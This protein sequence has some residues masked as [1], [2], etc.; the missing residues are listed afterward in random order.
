V[1]FEIVFFG[2]FRNKNKIM[3]S[4]KEGLKTF[5]SFATSLPKMERR[6]PITHTQ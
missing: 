3:Y 2:N 1:K 6:N 5:D 4:Q